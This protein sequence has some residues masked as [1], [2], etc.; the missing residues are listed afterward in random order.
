VQRQVADDHFI[1]GCIAQLAGQAVIVE[2]H[3][4]VCLPMY[5]SIEVG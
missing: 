5:L 3:S 4:R 2:P 1:S